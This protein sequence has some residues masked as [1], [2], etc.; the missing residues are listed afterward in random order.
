MELKEYQ[1]K[2]ELKSLIE[3]ANF[4]YRN[5]LD[6]LGEV[7]K[8]LNEIR[9]K[10]VREDDSY[11]MIFDGVEMARRESYYGYSNGKFLKNDKF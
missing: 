10:Y 11:L 3:R 1:E 2:K 7:G 8:I 6:S 9:E 5:A 4:H